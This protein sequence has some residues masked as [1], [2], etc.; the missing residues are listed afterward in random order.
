MN[1]VETAKAI[2]CN[3]IAVALAM[4]VAAVEALLPGKPDWL[5][6]VNQLALQLRVMAGGDQPDSKP[7][8]KPATPATQ[9][10]AP[11]SQTP[12]SAPDID[13]DRLLLAYNQLWQFVHGVRSEGLALDDKF[14]ER[15]EREWTVTTLL[16]YMRNADKSLQERAGASMENASTFLAV[17]ASEDGK[18]S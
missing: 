6:R 4:S 14:C 3:V 17:A 13:P 2:V 5:E 8:A 15:V 10:S 12:S 1:F 11:A 16:S 7:Q 9:R 18:S